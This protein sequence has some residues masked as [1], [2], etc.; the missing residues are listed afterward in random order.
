MTAALAYLSPRIAVLPVRKPERDTAATSR[1]AAIGAASH[2]LRSPLAAILGYAYTLRERDSWDTEHRRELIDVIVASAEKLSSFVDDLLDVARIDGG[3]F[4]LERE[5]IR[6]ERLVERIID[7]RRP[8]LEEGRLRLEVVGQPPIVEADAVRIEQVITNLID[9]AIRYSR[10]GSPIVVRIAAADG[11]RVSVSD[12]GEGIPEG[13][14]ARLFDA[15]FRGAAARKR[16]SGGAGLGLYLSKQ[17]VAA[18]G[19]E[20]WAESTAGAG[21]TFSFTVPPS[22]P[23]GP[24]PSRSGRY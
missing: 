19:G 24:R 15:F 3:V 2:E 1:A 20:I 17:I 6:I 11:V 5:S 10:A 12:Q 18:H 9:N 21:S 13:D 7:L 16:T 8:L 23:A 22:L 4:R 14:L